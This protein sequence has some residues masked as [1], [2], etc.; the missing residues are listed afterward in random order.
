MAGFSFGGVRTSQAPKKINVSKYDTLLAEKIVEGADGYN[1]LVP[2][3]LDKKSTAL[4]QLIIELKKVGIESYRVIAT[5]NVDSAKDMSTKEML[6]VESN[7][8]DLLIDYQPGF[9]HK[10]ILAVGQAMYVV[11]RSADFDA[12]PFLDEWFDE[13]KYVA[14]SDFLKVD[15]IVYPAYPLVDWYSFD[16]RVVG[17]HTTWRGRHARSQIKRMVEDDKDV[18]KLVDVR[19]YEVRVV[20][21]TEEAS[22]VLS[23]LMNSEILAAD[24]ETGGLNFLKHRIG[25]ITLCNDGVVGYYIP[26]KYIEDGLKRKLFIVLTSAKRLV[27]HNGKFDI[28]FMWRDLD[29]AYKLYPTDDTM[30]LIHSIHTERNQ[31]L[32]PGAYFYTYFGGYDNV[33]DEVKEQLKVESY[34][35]I[36][37]EYLSK[38]AAIDS[39]VA[40]RMLK[41]AEARAKWI[42]EKY[43][44]W[45]DPNWGI[46]RWYT[47]VFMPMANDAIDTEYEGLYIDRD[48]L[49]FSRKTLNEK[50]LGYKKKLVEIWNAEYNADIDDSFD[51]GSVDDVGELIE[52]MGWPVVKLNAKEAYA[53]DESSLMEWK[54]QG[55]KGTQEL[56]DLRSHLVALNSFVGYVEKELKKKKPKKNKESGEEIKKE[57][58][59]GFTSLIKKVMIEED[60]GWEKHLVFHDSEGRYVDG[61]DSSR[62]DGT[63]RMHPSINVM[64]TNTFRFSIQNPSLQNIPTT[65]EIGKIVKRCMSVPDLKKYKLSTSDYV[66]LQMVLVFRDTVLNKRGVD[67]IMHEI[68]GV[69][70]HK[71]PHS[72]TAFKIFYE[73]VKGQVIEVVDEKGKTHLF[74]EKQYVET[75][76]GKVRADQ[77][78]EDDELI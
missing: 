60:G 9:K 42:D 39:I 37:E 25:C 44:N 26:W 1:V 77:L 50:I 27:F 38:Y 23:S 74:H 70:G 21:T 47:D 43:P 68:Y 14:C 56:L 49:E 59:V 7:W 18:S 17:D 67:R 55:F 35:D 13:T 53:T 41:A 19:P 11:N 2:F 28:K 73:A 8:N 32:K 4:A 24:L 3:P 65:G 12:Y 36:P 22:K 69:N 58:P 30:C 75:K 66:G 76:R 5:C 31:G 10:I 48:E 54:M 16:P 45:K 29:C 64:G 62:R 34:L 15:A 72:A 40:W 51:F 57:K 52:K 20:T 63:W 33:L 6:K 78:K 71:D 46:W 61:A